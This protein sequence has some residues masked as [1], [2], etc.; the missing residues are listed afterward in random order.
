MTRRSLWSLTAIVGI[1]ALVLLGRVFLTH[2]AK[3]GGRAAA[4]FPV[5][6]V[7]ED[8][9][10]FEQYRPRFQPD[11]RARA[12]PDIW[13]YVDRAVAGTVQ[14]LE[15][16]HGFRAE[17]VYSATIKGFAARLTA[18][19][20]QRLEEHDWV[21]A[22][23]PDGTMTAIVQTL[24]WG[25]D[26]VEADLSST[27]AGD[28]SGAIETVNAYIIDT[29]IDR[30]HPDLNVVNHVNFTGLLGGG[31]QDCHGHGTHVAGTVGARDDAADVVG[32][33]PGVKLT[34]VKVL[35]CLG[36]GA[37]STVIQG[38][39]W[40]TANARKPA[41]ANMS[42]GGSTSDALD[43]AVRRSAQ[44]GIVYAVAAGNS[45]ANACTGSPARAGAGTN[46]GIITVAA[47]DQAD[48]EASFSNFGPC[49]D[50]WAPG[51]SI[52][53]TRN[54]GGTTTMSGTSMASPHA[55]GVA[56]LLLN[57]DGTLTAPLV[58]GQLKFD[59]VAPGTASKDGRPIR[60]VNASRS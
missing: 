26:R 41:V 5:I 34:G 39:D 36:T 59:A 33:A 31:N 16:V 18:E 29:G 17:H 4:R 25:V 37:T 11:E 30:T 47:T 15:A 53:S 13:G 58:E 19:Q 32:V 28:G 51:V 48:R 23:E 38:V 44:S 54:G 6:V 52:L 20:I 46:N 22:V 3:L 7:L 8:E 9:A 49:V 60:L 50:L 43:N 1:V 21:A 12:R 42:L 14:E 24:P 45:G 40:V 56:A 57:Q 10:P 55:A 27:R 2:G 35:D